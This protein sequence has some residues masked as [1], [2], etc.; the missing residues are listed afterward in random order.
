MAFLEYIW[1]SISNYIEKSLL[2]AP[3]FHLAL[4]RMICSYLKR[5][6]LFHGNLHG[7]IIGSNC[8]LKYFCNIRHWRFLL[9]HR[10]N[11]IWHG[12]LLILSHN[13]FR[14]SSQFGFLIY[15]VCQCHIEAA[16]FENHVRKVGFFSL[17]FQT[18]SGDADELYSLSICVGW[19]NATG[20]YRTM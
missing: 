16:I 12:L 1:H 6:I 14:T 3:K 10:A 5:R 18:D 7:I 11:A 2:N 8:P 17:Y 9:H 13:D 19:Y 15:K 20:G 4:A